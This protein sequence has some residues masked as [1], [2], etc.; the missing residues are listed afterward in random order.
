MQKKIDGSLPAIANDDEAEVEAIEEENEEAANN[1]FEQEAS[2]NGQLFKGL[3]FFISREVPLYLAK[4]IIQAC[5]GTCGW[6]EVAGH[7]SPFQ[8][9]DSRITIQI[10]DRPSIVNEIQGREYIQP[11]WLYDCVNANKLLKT[12]GYHVGESLPPHLSPFVVAGEDDYSPTEIVKVYVFNKTVEPT[13][14]IEEEVVE[15]EESKDEEKE[16]AK[17]MMSKRDRKLY[18]KMQF[19]KKRKQEAAEK[20]RQ[21]KA[22][23]NK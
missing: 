12:N 17:I 23:I 13:A 10:T 9:A 15:K 11:Q 18:D 1:D 7:G 8:E 3:V 22:S 19:G 16:L 21:K 6:N 5:G 2:Y 14:P 4:F 20:L